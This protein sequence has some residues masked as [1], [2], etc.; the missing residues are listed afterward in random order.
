[1]SFRRDGCCSFCQ[2]ISTYFL[3]WALSPQE[4]AKLVGSQDLDRDLAVNT[5]SRLK[6]L[7]LGS[8][9]LATRQRVDGRRSPKDLFPASRRRGT[10][11]DLSS[12]K[13]GNHEQ[14]DHLSRETLYTG[15]AGSGVFEYIFGDGRAI[16]L[17]PQKKYEKELQGRTTAKKN[18]ERTRGATLGISE[19]LA[20]GL[21]TERP[22]LDLSLHSVK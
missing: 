6:A 5:R 4:K 10:Q 7:S 19:D 14:N 13:Q 9:S 15:L 3:L 2:R 1:M 20:K 16:T 21:F 18:T 17:H 8:T 12:P 11:T 22:I